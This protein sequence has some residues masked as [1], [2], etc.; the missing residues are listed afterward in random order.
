M[1][2]EF[3]TR[4]DIEVTYA[5]IRYFDAE[6]EACSS[7]VSFNPYVNCDI[8]VGLTVTYDSEVGLDEEVKK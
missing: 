8:G 1:K 7:W 4:K 3:L 2:V 6:G 5:E